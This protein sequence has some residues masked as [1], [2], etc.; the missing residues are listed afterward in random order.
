MAFGVGTLKFEQH[1]YTKLKYIK[2]KYVKRQRVKEIS[3]NDTY[4]HI[5][6]RSCLFR[7]TKYSMQIY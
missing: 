3:N 5:I 4:P 2:E 7:D 1:R 6:A